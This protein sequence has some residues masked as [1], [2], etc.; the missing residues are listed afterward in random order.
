MLSKVRFWLSYPFVFLSALLMGLA[1]LIGS[2]KADIKITEIFGCRLKPNGKWERYA[3]T[4]W[5]EFDG[6]PK[7]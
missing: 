7:P 4:Y 3:G 1:Q 6:E 5:V 2:F